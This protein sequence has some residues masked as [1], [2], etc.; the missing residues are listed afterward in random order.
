[1]TISPSCSPP[2]GAG[3]RHTLWVSSR[4]NTQETEDRETL[5]CLDDNMTTGGLEEDYR[6]T[7][8]GLEE[9]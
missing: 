5:S 2:R 1:L 8:G 7:T 4:V 3:D 9:D 6:R